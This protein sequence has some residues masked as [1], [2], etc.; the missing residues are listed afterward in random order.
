MGEIR[1]WERRG[2]RGEMIES[3]VANATEDVADLTDGHAEADAVRAGDERVHFTLKGSGD[4]LIA[5]SAQLANLARELEDRL[6]TDYDLHGDLR[7]WDGVEPGTPGWRRD[8]VS[9]AAGRGE[10]PGGGGTHGARLASGLRPGR[11]GA[12]T[13]VA[14]RVR[15]RE[16]ANSIRELREIRAQRLEAPRGW[17]NPPKTPRAP[18]GVPTGIRVNGDQGHGVRGPLT[19]G[20]L[21][22]VALVA[23]QVQHDG[24]PPGKRGCSGGVSTGNAGGY[25]PE[26]K[27]CCAGAR[28]KSA[29]QGD[30]RGWSPV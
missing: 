25:G 17:A 24:I 8:P 13:W 11:A 2:E 4:R 30:R 27:G 15:S 28:W 26:M 3:C 19:G 10:E 6:R 1:C 12:T 22:V 21:G 23:G 14:R 5:L 9:P 18:S 29:V 16:E 20:A 7:A